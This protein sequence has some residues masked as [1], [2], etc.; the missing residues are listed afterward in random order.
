MNKQNQDID[1][2]T[3][4][5]IEK[6]FFIDHEVLESRYI[7]LQ[8]QHHPDCGGNAQYSAAISSG[9][10]ILSD[11][12]SR[13]EY[14]LN[15][16]NMEITPLSISDMSEMIDMMELDNSEVDRILNQEMENMRTCF[17]EQNYEKASLFLIKIKALRR[18]LEQMS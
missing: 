13:A 2:Y 8:S 11:E 9:Y 6:S 16:M 5:G 15:V 7:S 1:Y 10:K 3:M 18:V 12:M 4:F 17:M 14:I